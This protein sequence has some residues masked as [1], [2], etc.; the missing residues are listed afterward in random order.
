MFLKK[1]K[2]YYRQKRM[3][4]VINKINKGNYAFSEV[5]FKIKKYCS[6][7]LQPDTRPERNLTQWNMHRM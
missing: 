1:G 3:K 6:K 7:C 4:I 5:I 2:F